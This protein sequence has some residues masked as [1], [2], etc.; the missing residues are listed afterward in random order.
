MA[1]ET[2]IAEH[3]Y[4]FD[5]IHPKALA[6]R[7]SSIQ[8]TKRFSTF[9]SHE[10]WQLA[11]LP[12]THFEEGVCMGVCGVRKPTNQIKPLRPARCLIS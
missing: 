10:E 1:L 5:N 2:S 8:S 6:C 12:R 11:G 4:Y 3:V 7:L 9:V